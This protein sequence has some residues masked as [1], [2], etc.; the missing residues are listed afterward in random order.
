MGRVVLPPG[1]EIFE[2][3]VTFEVAR[4]NHII[5][6]ALTKSH[7]GIAVWKDQRILFTPEG[8]TQDYGAPQLRWRP[9]DG[10]LLVTSVEAGGDAVW[11]WAVPSVN[12]NTG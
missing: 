4:N 2:N 10:A 3:F 5:W 1:L 8:R 12:I 7:N 11:I 6:A 9:S